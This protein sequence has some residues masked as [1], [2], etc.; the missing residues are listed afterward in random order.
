[1]KPVHISHLFSLWYILMIVSS[2][3]WSSSIPPADIPT[4]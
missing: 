3:R 2:Y 4:I 1:M